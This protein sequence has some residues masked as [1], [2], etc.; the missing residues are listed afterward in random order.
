MVTRPVYDG[1]VDDIRQKAVR[2]EASRQLMNYLKC[3][4]QV[5]SKL[6]SKALKGDRRHRFFFSGFFSEL[7]SIL[8]RPD[9]RGMSF[10]SIVANGADAVS[11][12]ADL[13]S[14]ETST[15]IFGKD[16]LLE[17]YGLPRRLCCSTGLCGTPQFSSP[18][19]KN[20][21]LQR[22]NNPFESG[23]SFFFSRKPEPPVAVQADVGKSLALFQ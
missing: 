23:R 11:S 18:A 10:N 7:E 3:S 20:R 17:Q 19:P 12:G 16:K 14:V 2:G 13:V 9:L 4:S 1:T 6:L 5:C 15:S 21:N 8:R 22:I